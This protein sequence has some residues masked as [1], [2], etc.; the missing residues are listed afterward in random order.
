M[1]YMKVGWRFWVPTIF[2]AIG[3]LI[4]FAILICFCTV[5]KN[6]HCA[7][8][9]GASGLFS[10][11]TFAMHLAVRF[12]ETARISPKTFHG[13]MATGVLGFLTGF[14]VFV[15]YLVKGIIEK[16]TGIQVHGSYIVTVWGFMLFKWGL[17][18]FLHSKNYKQELLKL[19]GS[20]QGLIIRT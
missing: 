8:W 19:R 4:G 18:L 16:E 11:F 17:A 20:V 14:G 9:G 15:G 13:L 5:Y 6:Y 10:A 12:D 1:A 7:A 3:F 2:S